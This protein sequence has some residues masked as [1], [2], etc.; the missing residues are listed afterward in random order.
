VQAVIKEKTQQKVV[1]AQV[2]LEITDR[3]VERQKKELEGVSM[4]ELMAQKN[5]SEAVR[6]G[7]QAE[8]DKIRMIGESV[9][10]NVY[11]MDVFDSPLAS[12]CV[13]Q[14]SSLISDGSGECLSTCRRGQGRSSRGRGSC[15]SKCAREQGRSM[16]EVWRSC[17][18]AGA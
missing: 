9:C 8:A 17:F 1:E 5:Q 3:E 2:H 12:L 7:A 4:A 18:G 14:G 15:R 16:G 11:S 13:N 6:V 10:M